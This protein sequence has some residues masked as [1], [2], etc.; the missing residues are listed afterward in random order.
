MFWPKG[1]TY[2]QKNPFGAKSPEKLKAELKEAFPKITVFPSDAVLQEFLDERPGKET[3]E[4][5]QAR[6]ADRRIA[7]LGDAAGDV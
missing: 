7:L 3:Y 6:I 2:G 1:Q 5:E 4:V